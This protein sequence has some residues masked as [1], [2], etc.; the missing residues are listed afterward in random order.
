MLTKTQKEYLANMPMDKANRIV[1]IE[2]YN[3]KTKVIAD[4]YVKKIKKALPK[5]K[6]KFMG[7]SALK[8]SG[9]NDVDIWVLCSKENQGVCLKKLTSIFNQNIGE[10]NSWKLLEDDITVS[11]KLA[12]PEDLNTKGQLAHFRIFRNNPDLLKNYENLKIKMDG[13]TYKEYATAKKDFLMRVYCANLPE[14]I[15]NL[16][17]LEKIGAVVTNSHVITPSGRHAKTSFTKYKLYPHVKE[18]FYVAKVI[19]KQFKNE[20]IEA[21]MG[22]ATGGDILSELVAYW[23][24]KITK[25]EVLSFYVKKDHNGDLVFRDKSNNKLIKN[26]KV[27]IVDDTLD[28]CKTAKIIIPYINNLGAKIAGMG[29]ICTRNGILAEDLGIPKFYAFINNEDKINSFLPE[30]CPMCKR[31]IPINTDFGINT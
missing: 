14:N 20:K 8:I 28:T 25:N 31:G 23:L 1:R 7:A 24:E 5:T 27:L 29:V 2:T 6:V 17:Y 21:V 19:A 9:L 3:S 16:K 13:K 12:N 18:T 4:E 30:D 22:L 10:K 11:V 15:I 26:K